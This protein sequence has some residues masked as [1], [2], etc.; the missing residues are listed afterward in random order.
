MAK[1]ASPG[2]LCEACV[3]EEAYSFS[4]TPDR[5][6]WYEPRSG[7]WRYTG[8]CTSHS[9]HYYVLFRN[10]GRGFMDSV[11]ERRDWLRHLSY[12]TWFDPLDFFL[13][14]SRFENAR[15]SCF[16]LSPAKDMKAYNK[17]CSGRGRCS[18]LQAHLFQSS[19]VTKLYGCYQ[20]ACR[21][22]GY[23]EACSQCG[24]PA[25]EHPRPDSF[26]LPEYGSRPR[27]P[28]PS[29]DLAVPRSPS[30]TLG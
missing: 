3:R 29:L 17:G 1:V 9:E 11:R 30:L 18:V 26:H 12:K 24:F 22:N 2:P 21:L 7:T 27:S 13:M 14:W 20:I 5:A 8:G 15:P 6:R 28:F 19:G 4:W 25:D 23:H 10:R 16:R